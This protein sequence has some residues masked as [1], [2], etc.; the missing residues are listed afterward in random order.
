[1]MIDT[2]QGHGN[3]YILAGGT[4]WE[5]E[6]KKIEKKKQKRLGNGNRKGCETDIHK[7]GNGN[8][9]SKDREIEM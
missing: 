2:N 7:T 6:M 1:M 3:C 5:I 9:S 8:R 4:S